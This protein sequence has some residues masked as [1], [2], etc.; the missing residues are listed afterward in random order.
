MDGRRK[1]KT[2]VTP[3]AQHE[4]MRGYNPSDDWLDD[5][6]VWTDPRYKRLGAEEASMS[7]QNVSLTYSCLELEG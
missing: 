7:T 6:Q 1:G 2:D 3:D 4:N 5:E